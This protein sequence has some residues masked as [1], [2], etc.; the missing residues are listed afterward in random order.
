MSTVAAK[1]KYLRKTKELIK[2]KI[3]WF[4][5][6]PDDTVF[7]KY[8]DYIGLIGA[9]LTHHEVNYYYIPAK[10]IRIKTNVVVPEV[11]HKTNYVYRPCQHY[12]TSHN[13]VLPNLSHTITVQEV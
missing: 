4:V 10:R 7:R 8:P 11:E 1:L 2:K 5:A 12:V 13:V 3:Q 6:M 9:K